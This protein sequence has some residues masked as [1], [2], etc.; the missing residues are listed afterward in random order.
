M[1]QIGKN[2]QTSISDADREI[3]TLG[4][5]ENA[6]KSVNLVSDLSVYS[7]DGISR[8]ALDLCL[9]YFCNENRVRD[10]ACLDDAALQKWKNKIYHRSLI[11]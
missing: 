5:T 8:S 1:L 4:S 3:T 6:G 7:Q 2:T 10:F 9:C 11:Q